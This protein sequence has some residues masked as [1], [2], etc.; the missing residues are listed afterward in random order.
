MSDVVVRL[1]R[2]EAG[3]LVDG[4]SPQRRDAFVALQA[5]LRAALDSPPVEEYRAVAHG[6]RMS[7]VELEGP[8]R[9]LKAAGATVARS[10]AANARVQVRIPASPWV[11]LE[12]GE[13]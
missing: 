2:E 10:A 4:A 3:A 13:R 11:D 1:S 8:T 9:S 6:R 5:K 12:E 7:L